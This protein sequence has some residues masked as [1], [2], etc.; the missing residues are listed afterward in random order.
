MNFAI[1]SQG[2]NQVATTLFSLTQVNNIAIDRTAKNI[3][4]Y[5]RK[6]GIQKNVYYPIEYQYLLDTQQY[7]LLMTD[8]SFFQFFF[9]F[10]DAD[11]LVSAR[12]A[13]YPCPVKTS[14]DADTLLDAAEAALDREDNDLYDHLF[15]WVELLETDIGKPANTSHFRFDFDSK[16]TAHS[17]SHLQFGAIQ[18]FRIPAN[19]FPLPAAFIQLCSPLFSNFPTIPAEHLVFARDRK[20]GQPANSELIF[21]E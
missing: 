2:L 5:G 13:Y 21:I 12:L 17:K 20:F 9:D 6:P 11:E 15:N 4:W 1:A 16:V 18:E 14:H 10:N 3:G 7:S 19:S 8:S